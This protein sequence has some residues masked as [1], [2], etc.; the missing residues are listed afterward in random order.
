MSDSDNEE[1]RTVKRSR[2]LAEKRCKEQAAAAKDRRVS[3][4]EVLVVTPGKHAGVVNLAEARAEE[5][6]H[7]QQ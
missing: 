7:Q 5:C 2:R 1:K 6:Q 3:V 4:G